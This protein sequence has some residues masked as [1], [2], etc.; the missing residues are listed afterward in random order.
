MG[1]SSTTLGCTQHPGNQ[2]PTW[3]RSSAE[4]LRTAA[5]RFDRSSTSAKHL[6][7]PSRAR[8]SGF[9]EPG[10]DVVSSVT[11]G[12]DEAM[13][14]NDNHKLIAPG[15]RVLKRFPVQRLGNGREV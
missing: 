9:G 1:Y 11:S 3:R 13:S 14:P 5:V 10:G 6:I 4:T 15:A 7:V 12:V 8:V 2:T